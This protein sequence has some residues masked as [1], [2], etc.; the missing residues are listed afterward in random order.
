MLIQWC[1]L[2]SA[3]WHRA[4]QPPEKGR[5]TFHSPC[6]LKSFAFSIVCVHLSSQN[7]IVQSQGQQESSV[8]LTCLHKIPVESNDWKTPPLASFHPC[9]CVP[10]CH[11]KVG[12]ILMRT[13]DVLSSLHPWSVTHKRQTWLSLLMKCRKYPSLSPRSNYND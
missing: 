9:F 6:T 2:V 1:C 13:G 3:A 8:Q 5:G 12:Q 10:R 11:T 4:L 7:P